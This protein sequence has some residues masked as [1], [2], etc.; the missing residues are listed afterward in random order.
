MF[1]SSICFDL[2]FLSSEGMHKTLQLVCHGKNKSFL[3]LIA[4]DMI[5]GP[6]VDENR[7]DYL[8]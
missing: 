6:A 1:S 8:F 2:L 7:D 3:V 5:N 4:C